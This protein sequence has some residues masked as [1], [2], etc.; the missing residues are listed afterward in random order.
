MQP[1][2]SVAGRGLQAAVRS[3][4][5]ARPAAMEALAAPGHADKDALCEEG[6]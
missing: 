5:S 6:R 4:G 3:G 1:L 2:S